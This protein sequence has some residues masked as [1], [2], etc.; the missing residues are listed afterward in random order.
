[1]SIWTALKL[2]ALGMKKCLPNQ[3]HNYMCMMYMTNDDHVQQS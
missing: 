3:K 1:M 2:L